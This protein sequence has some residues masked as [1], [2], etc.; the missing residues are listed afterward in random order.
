MGLLVDVHRNCKLIKLLFGWFKWN[1]ANFTLKAIDG[2]ISA[3]GNRNKFYLIAACPTGYSL[4]SGSKITAYLVILIIL[5][6]F[7]AKQ[8]LGFVSLMLKAINYKVPSS[9]ELAVRPVCEKKC[10]CPAND[11]SK[12]EVNR[13]NAGIEN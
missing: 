10:E 1:I 6:L 9:L 11:K 5:V 4:E 13:G 2:F 7:V 8:A 3:I 12:Y